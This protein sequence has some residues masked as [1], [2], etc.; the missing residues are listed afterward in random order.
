MK[1]PL[2]R[3]WI[4]ILG[5]ILFLPSF[6]QAENNQQLDVVEVENVLELRQQD[7]DGSTVYRLT[8]EVILTF[9]QYRRG[10]KF[11]QDETA[12][13]L[14]DDNSRIIETTYKLND[15]ITGITGTLSVFRNNFQ[16][17]PVEDPGEA[18]SS[19]NE[20][21]IVE[22]T[23]E[24]I[25]PDDQGRLVR[26]ADLEFG[27]GDHGK[28]FSTGT[29][30]TVTDPTGSIVFRTEFWDADYIG[31]TIPDTPRD[32]VALVIM[33]NDTRQIVSRSLADLQITD[34]PSIRALRN[35]EPGTDVV[36]TLSNEVILTF[37]QNWNNQKW[38]QDETAGIMI[39][40]PN[41]IITT[42]YEINDGITGI[43]AKLGIFRNNMQ[44]L[45]VEDPG[46]ASSSGNEPLVVERSLEEITADDQGRLVMI[47]GLSFDGSYHGQNFSTGTNYT[48]ADETDTMVF[49]TEFFDADYI[50]TAI[51]VVPQDLTAIVH[52]FNTTRQVVARSLEDFEPAGEVPVFSVEFLIKDEDAE[53][54]EGATVTILE[55]TY[56]AGQYLVEELM[57]GTYSFTISLEGYHDF[58]G[59]FVLVSEDKEVEVMLIAVDPFL[60]D[61]FPW[62]EGF[63]EDFTPEGWTHYQL[64][65]AGSWTTHSTAYEGDLAAH[66]TFTAPGEE[67]NSWLVTPQIR[68]PDDETMLLSFFE[69][70]SAMGDYGYSGVW[71]SSGSGKPENGHFA[72]IYESDVAR[73]TYTER[74]LNLADYMGEVIYIAFVYQGED[75][76]GWWVDNVVVEEAPD[77]F[78]MPDIATLVAEGRTDGTVYKIT[79]EVF[80]THFQQAYR[81]QLYMQ[82]EGA[83]ILVD[84]PAGII[85]TAYQL[86]DGITGFIVT[87]TM[88]Q[89]MYQ[90]VPVEDPGAPSSTGNTVEPMEVTLSELVPEMQGMLVIV[91]DVTFKADNPPTFT[92]NQS[93]FILDATGEGEIRTPNSAGLLDYF[94]TDVP[95]E[96]KDLIGVLHQ[97]FN[98]LRLLPRSLADFLEPEDP[99]SAPVTEPMEFRL[100]PNPARDQFTVQGVSLIDQIRLFDLGGRMLLNVSIND[101]Q[102]VLQTGSLPNGLYIIQVISGKEI[103]NQRLQISR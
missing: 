88:F 56:E 89:D 22:R 25:S 77:V 37:Q 33:F 51:P 2:Q 35:Q 45:P 71:I 20:P 52:M 61:V 9:Q 98:V 53:P 75:A 87:L 92:H 27:E 6:S 70:N 59:Q 100:F 74:A 42:A 24:D 1:R 46:E 44:L 12:G 85:E 64:G 40:D 69:R 73:G 43:K 28:T 63:E 102:A 32:V 4:L 65:E 78:E 17:I 81:G 19:G 29:N 55:E 21:V 13:I 72:E 57:P 11:I 47:S 16:F 58:I 41:G 96:P 101:H 49:R 80:I 10:Q 48:V 79:G 83:A 97:R 14:I 82:D 103:V 50:G 62:M 91:R 76:H 94:G 66:H 26:I 8:G 93:Y 23:A 39:H 34:I 5:M 60:V 90:L 95:D 68:L 67:A 30:Y 31:A 99:T 84:D 3:T 18:S 38:V 86:Y 36:Y 15:G 7:A 54:L